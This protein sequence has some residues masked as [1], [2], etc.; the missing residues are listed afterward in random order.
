MVTPLLR[1]TALCCIIIG[2]L[3][4]ERGTRNVLYIAQGQLPDL[5]RAKGMTSRKVT[6][7]LALSRLNLSFIDLNNLILSSVPLKLLDTT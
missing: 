4:Y 1:N 3:R 6:L 7:L 2:A 5:Y